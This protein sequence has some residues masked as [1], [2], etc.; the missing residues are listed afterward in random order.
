MVECPFSVVV[1]QESVINPVLI[2]VEG[3]EK[4]RRRRR[5]RKRRRKKSH[6]L[7]PRYKKVNTANGVSGPSIPVTVCVLMVFGS[8]DLGLAKL[9][10]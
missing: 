3:R 2:G 10:V 6:S 7:S 5:R 8:N 9:V 1:L 4:R